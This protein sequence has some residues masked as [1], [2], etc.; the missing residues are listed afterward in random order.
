MVSFRPKRLKNQLSPT[1]FVDHLG[2]LLLVVHF[3]TMAEGVSSD[4][5][6]KN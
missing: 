6:G 3:G 5:P 1:A 4:V 2:L